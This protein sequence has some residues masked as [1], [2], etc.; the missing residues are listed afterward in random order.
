MAS[1]STIL[2][3]LTT[4]TAATASS[5]ALAA[6]PSWPPPPASLVAPLATSK[7]TSGTRNGAIR[8]TCGPAAQYTAAHGTVTLATAQSAVCPTPSREAALAALDATTTISAAAASI[9]AVCPQP[10]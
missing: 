2:T 1:V 8:S 9:A 3:A 4:S 7:I 5:A 10:A 6:C